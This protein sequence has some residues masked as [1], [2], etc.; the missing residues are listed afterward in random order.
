M[1]RYALVSWRTI[2]VLS[3]AVLPLAGILAHYVFEVE[4][5]VREPDP[6]LYDQ[7][8]VCITRN[9][10]LAYY[11]PIPPGGDRFIPYKKSHYV[12]GWN[13]RNEL[14]ISPVRNCSGYDH[15]V[16]LRSQSNPQPSP[17]YSQ[18]MRFGSDTVLVNEIK[19]TA[20]NS[21]FQ[22]TVASGEKYFIPSDNDFPAPGSIGI[23]EKIHLALTITKARTY[24]ITTYDY[25][26]SVRRSYNF[27]F[28]EMLKQ[29]P[30]GFAIEPLQ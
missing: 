18:T 11:V 7:S 21:K 16:F 4:L 1:T 15:V 13:G 10:G 27:D 12:I 9:L 26:N 30:N 17:V 22:L 5:L 2:A 25:V 29:Y 8:S 6:L 23:L 28:D 19:D 20:G 3:I 14:V 24:S